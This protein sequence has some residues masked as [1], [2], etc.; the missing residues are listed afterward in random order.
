MPVKEILVEPSPRGQTLPQSSI[1]N[2]LIADSSED[3]YQSTLDNGYFSVVPDF[4]LEV[5]LSE[6]AVKWN[7]TPNAKVLT[8]SLE[9][10]VFRNLPSWRLKGRRF[11]F[12]CFFLCN[13]TPSTLDDVMQCLE[14]DKPLIILRGSGGITDVLA[15]CMVTGKKRRVELIKTTVAKIEKILSKIHTPFQELNIKEKLNESTLCEI[16]LKS[17]SDIIER[18]KRRSNTADGTLDRRFLLLCLHLNQL[19]M[20]AQFGALWKLVKDKDPLCYEIFHEALKS[21]RFR[22]IRYMFVQGF[23]HEAFNNR[24]FRLPIR[25]NEDRLPKTFNLGSPADGLDYLFKNAIMQ[26]QH[27]FSTLIWRKVSSPFGAALFAYWMLME[28][29]NKEKEIDRKKVIEERMKVYQKYAIETIN[30]TYEQKPESA[31]KPLGQTLPKWGN[32]SCMIIALESENRTFVSQTACARFRDLTWKTGSPVPVD[33]SNGET[34]NVIKNLFEVIEII[35]GVFFIAI[36]IVKWYADTKT[37]SAYSVID[38]VRVLFSLDFICYMLCTLELF[39]IDKFLGPLVR[40]MLSLLGILMKVLIIITV[41]VLAYAIA[42]ESVLYPEKDLGGTMLFSVFRRP[43]WAI[44]AEFRLE[45]LNVAPVTLIIHWKVDPVTLTIH[46][47]VAPVTLIIHWKVDPVTLTIHGSVDPVTLTIHWKVDP[48]TLT[49]HW[50]VDPVT[51]TIHWKVDPVTL[52]IH[53]KVDPMTLTIHWKVDP[54]TLTIHGTV[55]PV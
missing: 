14:Q 46:W 21:E 11:C 6:L 39:Y 28:L 23:G 24:Q 8:T 52:T 41:F 50:K 19:D 47:T 1:P 33:S 42:S 12:E 34:S 37:V 53:W 48:V 54:V 32:Q 5:T 25:D 36:W 55:D 27:E 7:L 2:V 20:A 44:F 49:I 17:I 35:A 40:I 45:E 4:N 13:G 31:L 15:E 18:I 38:A 22:F 29:R 9:N 51:L 43:F 10:V 16:I 26:H 30:I 3:G